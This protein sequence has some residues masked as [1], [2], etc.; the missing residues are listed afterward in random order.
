MIQ[1]LR[2]LK[3]N[4]VKYIL[5]VC[6]AVQLLCT[7][8]YL[9]NFVQV[10]RQAA[11]E[12]AD[13][14]DQL[15]EAISKELQRNN[16]YLDATVFDSTYRQMFTYQGMEWV[17]CASQ[18]QS[19]Y[20]LCNTQATSDYYF[21]TADVETG[22]FFEAVTVRVPFENYREVRT[23]LLALCAEGG[24]QVYRLLE[25]SDGSRVIYTI[26]RY[27]NFAC[28]CWI[29]EST[30]LR[31]A[32]VIDPKVMYDLVLTSGKAE[33]TNEGNYH[34]LNVVALPENTTDEIIY[35]SA[36]ES[37][38][39]VSENGRIT[40]VSEGETVIYITCGNIQQ[41]CPVVCRFTV[42]TQPETEATEAAAGETEE[43]TEQTTAPTSAPDVVLKLE[44][45]D[46]M[47]GVY[48]EFQ[49]KLD[50]DLEQNQVTWTSEHPHIA[51]V[52]ENGVVKA[53]KSGTTAITAKYGDQEVSCIVRCG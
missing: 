38:A 30:F 26:W 9:V 51:T 25:L 36:D 24:D 48:Y 15:A 40:A 43:Q 33:L 53:L 17:N 42:E 31:S 5:V 1:W 23:K 14:T 19:M 32:A 41:V 20:A 13:Y 12:L 37:I 29:P 7:G 3:S 39:T 21:F 2:S 35:T 6:V 10:R 4:K 52:D 11:R 44:K 50:C 49:L 16:T 28:G 34:L 18:L 45:T 22:D 46:V 27:D 8:L 47:L